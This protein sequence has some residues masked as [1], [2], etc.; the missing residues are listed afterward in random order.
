MNIQPTPQQDLKQSKYNP[1]SYYGKLTHKECQPISWEEVFQLIRA[2]TGFGDLI[3]KLRTEPDK[4]KRDELKKSLPA[5]TVSGLFGE[6]R[7]MEHLKLHSGFIQMDFD[8]VSNIPDAVRRLKQDKYSFA[9][10]LSPTGTGIKLIVKIPPHIDLHITY[11]NELKSYYQKNFNLEVDKQCKDITRLL[12]LS[13][14]KELF[15]NEDSEIW[16]TSRSQQLSQFETVL[17]KLQEKESFTQGKRNDF[18]YKLARECQKAEIEISN[19]ISEITKSFS[20]EDFTNK[21]IEATVKSAYKDK[22]KESGQSNEN[23][24][25]YSMLKK[26]EIYLEEK[27]QIRLNEVS[28]MIECKLRG[29]SDKYK[30]LNENNIYRELQ[31]QN[32]SLSM[33]KLTSLL[34]SDFVPTYNPFNQYFEGLGEWEKDKDPDYIDKLC[35][36]IPVSNPNRFKHHFKKMLVRC[37]ACALE[38]ETFNKQVF[39][40]VGESQ[41]T[42]K[43]TFCRW[44]CPP[45][46]SDYITEYVNTDK[47]GLIVLATNLFINM[48]ELATLSKAEINSLK[49]F[50]SKDKINV[51]RP[52]AKRSSVHPRR[53]NFIGSTNKD[54]F[55]T[56]ET[57]SVRWLCFELAGAI[58]F[59]YKKDIDINDIWKQ[60]YA[61]YNIGFSYQLT[62][63]EIKENEAEN[64]KF[65]LD[66]VEVQLIHKYYEPASKEDGKFVQATDILNHII[67]LHS[68]V[69]LNIRTIGKAMK[70]LGFEK[71]SKYNPERRFSLHGYYVKEILE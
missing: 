31:H 60:A 66:S 32:L 21:E 6:S 55:L 11:F 26:V 4:A 65:F 45:A 22:I 70:T 64:S 63:T 23:P 35:G 28:G 17:T 46:L 61:I 33:L 57:G 9:V 3:Q 39:V 67:H 5:I 37:I 1:I 54:E 27:Y 53:A 18:V 19:A 41:N 56:D 40:L 51:R 14:D 58:N 52:F 36:Y 12:F 50:I 30:E 15:V 44:L 69:R 13:W 43:S 62:L 47:D 16:N 10:F 24:S 20:V 71:H 2:G 38:P 48:D 29:I 68:H 42:G 34:Q 25:G 7:K 49:S 59:D 8:N